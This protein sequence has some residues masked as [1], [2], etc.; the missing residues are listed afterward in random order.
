MKTV[1][2][3][4]AATINAMNPEPVGIPG[5]A[6]ASSIQYHGLADPVV[7][8]RDS[9]DYFEAVQRPLADSTTCAADETAN[10]YRLFLVPAWSIAAAVKAANVFEG[11]ARAGTVG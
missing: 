9:I 2:D 1:D 8:P 11:P 10:F 5:S 6:A 3:R 7:P 4:L